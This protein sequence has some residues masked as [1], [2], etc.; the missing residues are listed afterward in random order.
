M[1]KALLGRFLGGSGSRGLDFDP[2]VDF[3]S[4]NPAL[5]GLD[6]AQAQAGKD[7]A[8][9]Y[10]DYTSRI[11]TGGSAAS[12]ELSSL[13]LAVCRLLKPRRAVDLGSGFTSYVLRRHAREAGGDIEV[14]SVDD[15]PE[16]LSRTGDYLAEHG[17]ERTGLLV[18]EDFEAS[19][20]SAFDLTVLDVRPIKRRVEQLPRLVGG[21]RPGGMILVDDVHKP[22]MVQPMLELVARHSWV[23]ASLKSRTLD[24][25]GRFAAA[26]KPRG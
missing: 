24:R 22:H 10:A 5:A 21:L 3:V 12:L 25:H 11:S 20:D 18:W 17:L 7:L 2:A 16:W 19:G 13:L 23:C 9:S 15:S 14:L 4:F 8:E 26:I 6:Q 1:L